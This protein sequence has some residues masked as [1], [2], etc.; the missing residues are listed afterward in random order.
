MTRDEAR[1]TL[2]RQA[3]ALARR[4]Y[5]DAP[6]V[7][8]AVEVLTAPANREEIMCAVNEGV[9]LAMEAV[10]EAEFRHLSVD[11]THNVACL[12]ANAIGTVLDRPGGNV[13]MAEVMAE[14][15]DSSTLGDWREEL[16]DDVVDQ[17]LG[18]RGG[19]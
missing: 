19:A 4:N 5:D 10:A 1:R 17:A 6:I 14:N 2:L 3:D 8:E 9:D 7:A 15:F 16:G 18:L 11:D 13:T 12:V